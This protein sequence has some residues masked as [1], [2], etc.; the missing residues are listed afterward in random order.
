[1]VKKHCRLE[2]ICEKGMVCTCITLWRGTKYWCCKTPMAASP[3]WPSGI[4]CM[5]EGMRAWIF[6]ITGMKLSSSFKYC[7]ASYIL[8]Q[9][10]SSFPCL[11]ANN[12][13][14]GA[15]NVLK[16]MLHVPLPAMTR[17]LSYMCL[18]YLTIIRRVE[19]D[20]VSISHGQWPCPASVLFETGKIL[21]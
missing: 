9:W 5:R 8:K 11:T 12:T 21:C 14:S 4:S 2:K 1:M 6:L 18:S 7:A 10:L 13:Y 19:G 17:E 20:L 16:L 3:G 15:A